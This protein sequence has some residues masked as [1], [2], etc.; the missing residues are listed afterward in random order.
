MNF[1]IPNDYHRIRMV[2]IDPG[3]INCGIAIFNLNYSLKCVERIEGF[4][5]T[6]DRLFNFAGLSEDN[7]TDRIIK[8]QKLRHALSIVMYNSAPSIVVCESPFFNRLRPSAFEP[9]V[10][11]MTVIKQA[12]LDFNM[13]IMLD[14]LEPRVIKKAIGADAMDGKEAVREAV[15]RTEP[16]TNVL[17]NPID[18][19]DQ[20]AIDAVAIG[21][22]YLI[23]ERA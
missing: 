16:I 4:T 10:E 22:T 6:N 14:T 11:V 3:L 2:A 7:W 23:K 17:V 9:L 15:R 13:N 21:Y 1:V 18:S 20:H 5:L 8:L 12:V 19:L